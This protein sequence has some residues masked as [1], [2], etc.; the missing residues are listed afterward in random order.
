MDGRPRTA[1]GGR[2]E[3]PRPSAVRRP[4]SAV[5]SGHIVLCG[6]DRL[7]LRT[8]EELCRLGEE[9]V[10]VAS[11]QAAF[12][13]EA[14]ALG[15]TLVEGSHRDEAT[16]CAAGVPTAEAIL[17]VEDDDVG[18]LHAALAAQDLNPNLRIVLRMFNQELGRRIEELFRDCSAMTASAIAAPAFVSAA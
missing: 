18:N 5:Y 17:L 16:L 1:D 3:R 4:P 9:V 10:V 14:R 13:E 15:V 7:G 6:L 2:R 12:V 8:L 11:P